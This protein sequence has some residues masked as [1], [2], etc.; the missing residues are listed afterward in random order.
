[1]MIAASYSLGYE[2]ASYKDDDG[3]N[4]KT[5]L[6]RKIVHIDLIL[7]KLFN[8]IQLI[9]Q[10]YDNIIFQILYRIPCSGL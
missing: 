2:G 10:Y 4:S 3:T 7:R 5:V 9:F 8:I 1:M 6:K